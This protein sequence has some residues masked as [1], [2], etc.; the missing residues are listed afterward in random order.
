MFVH[1]HVFLKRRGRCGYESRRPPR[2]LPY[3]FG[4]EEGEAFVQ[5]QFQHSTQLPRHSLPADQCTD[6]APPPVNE[7][8]SFSID[9]R[10]Y[11]IVSSRPFH[12][13]PI[14]AGP[15]RSPSRT[16]R[17]ILITNTM[18]FRAKFKKALGGGG[19]SS[20][21]AS[22]GDSS[23]EKPDKS[24]LSKTGSR[25]PLKTADGQDWPEN[26][27]K[28]WEPMPRPKY[29]GPWNQ[30][31]QDKLS[32]FSFGSSSRRRRSSATSTARTGSEYSPMGSKLP[33]R[34]QSRRNSAISWSSFKGGRKRPGMGSRQGSGRDDVRVLEDGEEDDDVGNG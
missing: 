22:P 11:H 30:A 2:Y 7:C 17:K 31:H 33:S 21:T 26:V 24:F 8:L 4:T 27:Y 19:G 13:L 16:Y 3:C 15:F 23:S 28:P 29:R 10:P 6:V 25:R 34:G 9:L 14:H 18:P 20:G 32:A 1:E 12:Q 5:P